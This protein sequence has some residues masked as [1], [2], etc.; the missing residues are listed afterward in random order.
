MQK[1]S[2]RGQRSS[3]RKAMAGK[4]KSDVGKDP[5]RPLNLNQPQTHTDGHRQDRQFVSAARER[6]NS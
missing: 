4:Q 3:L 1:Q 2:A 5:P 6:P